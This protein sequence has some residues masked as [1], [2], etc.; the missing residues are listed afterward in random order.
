M[1]IFF[2]L[3]LFFSHYCYQLSFVYTKVFAFSY[4]R[5]QFMA[6]EIY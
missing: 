1:Q 3:S 6:L 2:S 5:S 4:V